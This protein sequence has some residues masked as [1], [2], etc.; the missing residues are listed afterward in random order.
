MTS[1]Q[2]VKLPS[3]FSR[4]AWSNLAAQSAEQIALSAAPIVAVLALGARE[5]ES[6]LLQTALTLP[7]LVFSIPAGLLADR[8]SRRKLWSGAEAWRAACV[9]V[10]WALLHFNSLTLG[11]MGFAG[12][13]AVCGTIAFS[14][15][16]PSIIPALVPPSALP[17]AIA[18][19]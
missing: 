7:F 17:F 4:L 9:I 13:I 16:A 10:L 11:I 2:P 3:G 5:V 19:I 6:G 8:V 1:P 15:A 14:F 12:F 18:R